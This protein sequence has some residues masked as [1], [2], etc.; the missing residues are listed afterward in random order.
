MAIDIIPLWDYA[1]PEA[2]EQRFRDLLVSSRGDDVLILQTQIARSYGLRKRYDQARRILHNIKPL[3]SASGTEAQVHYWLELGRTYASA[4]HDTASQTDATKAIAR[5]AYGRATELAQAARLDYLAI[6]AMHMMAFVDTAP[7][8]VLAIN[9]KTLAAMQ[10]SAQPEAQ[11]WAT[12]L[13]N[14]VAYGLHG[15]GHYEEAQVHFEKALKAAHDSGNSRKVRIQQ[16]MLAWNLRALKRKEE[17]LAAQLALEK[18]CEQA[19]EPDEYVFEE[20]AILYADRGDEAKAAHYRSK[21]QAMKA[22]LT[23]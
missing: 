5:D 7:E 18:D 17:A 13:Y 4:A 19:G 23:S 9:L 21:Q 3:L 20:L 16:W 10:A 14:N 2:S 11:R 15:V 6:D 8:A 1:K 22:P 12:S